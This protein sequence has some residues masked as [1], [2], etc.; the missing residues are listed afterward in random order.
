MNGTLLMNI[1]AEGAVPAFSWN[2]L[3]FGSSIRIFPLAQNSMLKRPH[4]ILITLCGLVLLGSVSFAD[5]NHAHFLSADVPTEHRLYSHDCGA[6]EL[7]QPLSP[8]FHCVTSCRVLSSLLQPQLS[9]STDLSVQGI[10]LT[11]FAALH[12]SGNCKTQFKRGPPVFSL[13]LP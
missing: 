12:P 10:L 11:V 8:P 7:H 5:L 13:S 4:T 2:G 1:R 6:A 3:H 9:L